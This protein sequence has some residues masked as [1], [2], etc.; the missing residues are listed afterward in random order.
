VL[1]SLARWG[2]EWMDKG[3][4][5][6]LEY[7]HQRC[8]HMTRPT[9]TCSECAEPLRPEEVRPRLGPALQDPNLP[10]QQAS[11]KKIPSLLKPAG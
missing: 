5:A 10:P 3:E 6:P 4:G 2:D 11:L 8:G 7:I 1:M 9:L